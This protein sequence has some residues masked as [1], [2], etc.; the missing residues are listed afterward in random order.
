MGPCVRSG[1]PT[2]DIPSTERAVREIADGLS[3]GRALAVLAALI[4]AG[5]VLRFLGLG[6][7]GL[8][9]DESN[10][11]LIASQDVSGI[12]QR[13]R[14]DSSP[15]L[16]YLLLHIWIR[17]FGMGPV[18]VK[19]LSV[20]CGTLLIPATYLLGREISGRRV[21]LWAAGLVTIAPAAVYYSRETRMYSLLPLLTVLLFWCALR[22]LSSGNRRALMGYLAAAALCLYTHNY[23]IF[24]WI[25]AASLWWGTRRPP[26][27]L[28]RWA[29]WQLL[30]LV[31]YV[32]WMPIL[33]HQMRNAT[34]Y[35]WLESFWNAFPP[36]TAL[37]R[38][39][40]TFVPGGVFPAYTDMGG[41][42]WTRVWV[43]LIALAFL[44]SGVTGRP[45]G[46]GANPSSS[47]L[48]RRSTAT[49]L[50]VPLLL[51][52]LYSL[53]RRPIYA[54]GR[55]DMI[56]Y[57]VFLILLTAGAFRWRRRVLSV[58]GFGLFAALSLLTLIPY[59]GSNHRT[60]DR[61]I[62]DHAAALTR[63]GDLII[64]TGFTRASLEYYLTS[65]RQPRRLVSFPAEA[66]EHL[67]NLDETDLMRD[68][69]RLAGEAA[70]IAGLAESNLHDGHTC[71]ILRSPM[72]MNRILWV[73]LENRFD[74]TL[75]DPPGGFRQAVLG[76][77][78]N[79]GRLALKD[80]R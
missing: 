59:Y 5:A 46:D 45:R 52:Y 14:L 8:W 79:V 72:K 37:Y 63:P 29:L 18:G 76:T 71:L 2:P 25:A 3:G 22:F 10:S 16:Y 38:T 67:G 9:L 66:A 34:H 57:P 20:L 48:A 44:L 74:M 69:N 24:A 30:I 68:E 55:T 64:C 12:V 13:L 49:M 62:A 61:E 40:E 28:G 65:R 32:P 47:L 56:V 73:A 78:V 41:L 42:P 23:G 26:I 4:V 39:V 1:G 33:V 11:V 54:V 35:R 77:P 27:G 60:G 43:P 6:A 75:A 58:G 50:L 70:R 31:F 80:G 53:L 21:G 19:S 36:W 7:M 15:I 17:I 51:P